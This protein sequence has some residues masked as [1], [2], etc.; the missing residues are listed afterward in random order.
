M[1]TNAFLSYSQRDESTATVAC[2]KLSAA[3]VEVFF[4]PNDLAPGDKLSLI[5]RR[6]ESAN[7]FVVLMSSA[8]LNS[9]WVMHELH[10]AIA[11]HLD[12][13]NIRIV[14]IRLERHLRCTAIADYRGIDLFD[15]TASQPWEDLLAAVNGK[16]VAER[17]YVNSFRSYLDRHV[18]VSASAM[19][20]VNV[21]W[22]LR[23]QKGEPL[24]PDWFVSD[25][26]RAE[27]EK[28]L[29]YKTAEHRERQEKLRT[30]LS[31]EKIADTAIDQA[32]SDYM[33]G[34]AFPP[35]IDDKRLKAAMD[36]VRRYASDEILD[37]AG[38][39]FRSVRDSNLRG[40][41]RDWVIERLPKREDV[42]FEVKAKADNLIAV[43]LRC[44]LLSSSTENPRPGSYAWYD[45]QANPSFDMGP[46]VW[47][48][49][50]L[51]V[52]YHAR[53]ER[54]EKGHAQL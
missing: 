39:L 21:M 40:V 45:S 47:T 37:L 29:N 17:S 34:E 41:T 33:T 15:L 32:V 38:D 4:A 53:T 20:T 14:P 10:T 3:G 12:G 9:R 46:M 52:D 42:N 44:G 5:H 18:T 54:K 25:Y 19:C 22:I 43:A 6:I 24:V 51:V 49:G 13:K 28:Y 50:E 11:L 48:I 23:P 7:V 30:V 1:S 2:T 26:G 27:A 31:R 8:A 16:P 35:V 36:W